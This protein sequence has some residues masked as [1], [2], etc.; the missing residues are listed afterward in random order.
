MNKWYSEAD[1]KYQFSQHGM[2]S[3]ADYGSHYAEHHG[4]SI[5]GH[6]G[7]GALAYAGG[8][9]APHPDHS[10]AE[11]L[12]ATSA[13][14]YSYPASNQTPD[15]RS[16]AGTGGD[17][18]PHAAAPFAN[19]YYGESSHVPAPYHGNYRVGLHVIISMPLNT[20]LSIFGFSDTGPAGRG[21]PLN[22]VRG[23]A[24]CRRR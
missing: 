21:V 15:W 5:T 24:R 16:R 4:G 3:A 2:Y 19:A 23:A 11:D 12:S 9:Y 8:D 22:G 6:S 18:G 1:S 20:D 10:S 17:G 14:Q 7:G 13:Y